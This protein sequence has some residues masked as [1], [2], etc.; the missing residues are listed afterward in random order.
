MS[1]GDNLKAE[2]KAP[3]VGIE[4]ATS[5]KVLAP[6]VETLVITEKTQ[7][8]KSAKIKPNFGIDSSHSN[9]NKTKKQRS[10]K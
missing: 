9:S 5:A 6:P 10:K 3:Q 7:G 4:N 2:L 1:E 8:E